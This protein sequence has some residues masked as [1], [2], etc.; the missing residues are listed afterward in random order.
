MKTTSCG[1]FRNSGF[2]LVEL[3]MVIALAG[4]VAVMISTVM[5]RPL[6][7]FADQSRRAE[8]T[9]LAA[10]ALNRMARDIRLAVP[11]SVRNEEVCPASGCRT[12]ELLAISE[13]G[14]YR[15]NQ[16]SVNGERYD[17]PRCPDSSGCSIPVLSP[18]MSGERVGEAR[19]LV[20]YNTG[21]LIANDDAPAVITPNNVKF[22]LG[23]T[24]EEPCL[25][26]TGAEGFSFEYASPQHRF[27]LVRD[28]LG[29]RCENPGTDTNGDGRGRILRGVFDTLSGAYS[30]TGAALVVD[31]VSG[32]SFTYTPGT[33][34][35]NGLVTLR[36]SLTKGGETISL[37][38]QV[39]VDNA[40]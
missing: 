7:G 34:T 35:R 38:Q 14:R 21:Q 25:E 16:W 27:Y 24:S 3:I 8:L 23:C 4:I 22:E 1:D 28:V 12:L 20:I 11:N 30:Y 33:N 31:S 9:D 19:W 2:T 18:G 17:P 26:L 29:Y 6:Q 37:L 5:S 10:M 39:H 36:L 13:G 40:P 32:C 15:A